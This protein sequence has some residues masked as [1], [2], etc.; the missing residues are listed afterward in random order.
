MDAISYTSA[1]QNLAETM[2]KV[3]DNHEPTIITRNGHESVVM[4]SLDD[5]NSLEETSYLLK[6]SK[7][8][9]RLIQSIVELEKG[10]G[11]ERELLD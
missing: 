8:T 6:S 5:Y 1:R 3:C 9:K 4:I 11:V 10:N 2:D 7:N